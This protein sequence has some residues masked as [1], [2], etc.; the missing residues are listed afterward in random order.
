MTSSGEV[1]RIARDFLWLAALAPLVSVFAFVFDGIYIGAT[2]SRDM[3][4]L[5]VLSLLSYLA[6]WFA[7]QPFGN[8]GLWI[9]YLTFYA[10]R[11]ALQALRYPSLL[12]ASFPDARPATPA[13]P[14]P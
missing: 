6:M 11:G 2:W 7:L 12:R 13:S 9:A 4:N 3:R 8:T 5:M 10:A 1:R 14:R